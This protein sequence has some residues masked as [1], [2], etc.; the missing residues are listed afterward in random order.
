[1]RELMDNAGKQHDSELV[2]HFVE[3]VEGG[4]FDALVSDSDI[5][6]ETYRNFA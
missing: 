2:N 4:A 6:T 3:L 1:M 5:V